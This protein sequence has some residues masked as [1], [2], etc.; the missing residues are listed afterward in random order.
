MC[1]VLHLLDT[2]PEADQ[3]HECAMGVTLPRG[4]GVWVRERVRV[5]EWVT[6]TPTL[7]FC[8]GSRALTSNFV[9]LES[10]SL[11]WYKAPG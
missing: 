1:P 6:S 10:K 4:T 11:Q 8:S 3:S 5:P 9:K 7:F 2:E